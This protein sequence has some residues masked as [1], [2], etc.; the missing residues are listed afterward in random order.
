VGIYALFQD[1][2]SKIKNS[3]IP[4]SVY[5]HSSPNMNVG[6]FCFFDLKNGSRDFLSFAHL[7]FQIKGV[8]IY[9]SIFF[10]SLYS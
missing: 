3:E 1:G 9:K 8:I 4:I 5:L 10:L 6:D 7:F 2:F